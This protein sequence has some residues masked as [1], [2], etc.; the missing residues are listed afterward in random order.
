MAA[1]RS[2]D[3]PT[4]RGATDGSPSEGMD[5]AG[6]MTTFRAS[7]RLINGVAPTSGTAVGTR[8]RDGCH[9]RLTHG[10]CARP[11]C[12]KRG[13]LALSG[14]APTVYRGYTSGGWCSA[15]GTPA[16]APLPLSRYKTNRGLGS[17]PS[18]NRR[19]R[20][21]EA[22]IG[23]PAVTDYAESMDTETLVI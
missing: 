6:A 13:R 20:P 9:D 23:G 15:C 16:R 18:G 14:R 1:R 7:S 17:H 10:A 21:A 4:A 12:K 2:A 3:I 19:G 22:T 8:H 5:S 11:N